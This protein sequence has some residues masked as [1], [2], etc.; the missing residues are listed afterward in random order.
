MPKAN[1]T[2]PLTA[3]TCAIG[4]VICSW[5]ACSSRANK[6]SFFPCR[7]TT[8]KSSWKL[9]WMKPAWRATGAV[10]AHAASSP[11]ALTPSSIPFWN[12]PNTRKTSALTTSSCTVRCCILVPIPMK[13]FMSTTAICRRKSI[14]AWPCG[15]TPIA[16]TPCRPS[17]ATALPICPMWWPSNTAPIALITSA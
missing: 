1:S 6:P 3:T 2:K 7:C 13:P 5:A 4:S 10:W 14:W 17:C 16:A 9:R 15:T 11:P 8:A 12:W